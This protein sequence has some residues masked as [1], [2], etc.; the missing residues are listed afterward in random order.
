M[1]LLPREEGD[2][3]AV[4]YVQ[5][6]LNKLRRFFMLILNDG[7]GQLCNRLWAFSFFI[8]YAKKHSLNIYIPHFREYQKYFK[9]LSSLPNVFFNILRKPKIFDT[10]TFLAYRVASRIL[11]IISGMINLTALHIYIDRVHWTEEQWP[12]SVLKRKNRLVFLG[13]WLHKKDVSALLEYKQMIRWLFEPAKQYRERVDHLFADLRRDHSIII[14]FHMRRRDL[15]GYLGG[16]YA[17]N[18][19]TYKFYM[20]VL[21][22]IFPDNHICYYLA[23]DEPI[24]NSAFHGY[25]T[26]CL[27]HPAMM[28]DLYALSLCH[29][30][31]GPRSTF[32]QWASFIGD[33]PLRLIKRHDEAITTD[34]FSPILYLGHFKNGKVYPA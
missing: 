2:L 16:A 31:V 10:T 6:F 12:W 22:D 29:Y 7:P 1:L 34:Q 11:R 26:A 27:L 14:G 28:E 17:F 23:S 9:N 25:E 32:S 24:D 13:S 21:Q 19:A 8:A 3:P 4:Y 30:I 33:V 5:D 15:R 18:D 20:G